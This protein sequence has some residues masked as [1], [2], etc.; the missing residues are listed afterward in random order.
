MVLKALII[1]QYFDEI[2]PRPLLF[3]FRTYEWV[4]LWDEYAGVLCL[5]GLL[6]HLVRA[7]LRVLDGLIVRLGM[8]A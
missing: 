7:G 3:A 4:D 5:Q 6:G 8:L 1:L 2:V